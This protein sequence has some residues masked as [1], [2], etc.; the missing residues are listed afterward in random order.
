MIERNKIHR[1]KT[2]DSI[3][4]TVDH[5]FVATLYTSF[6]TDS[7]LFFIMEARRACPTLPCP[8]LRLPQTC[9]RLLWLG[10]LSRRRTAPA[11][12]ARR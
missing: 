6:Q 7:S 2:E 11:L 5:P 1:V 9:H 10:C 4:T 3:L 8:P 12:A